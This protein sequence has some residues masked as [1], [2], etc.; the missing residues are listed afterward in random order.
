MNGFSRTPTVRETGEYAV[1]GGI[2]DLY[3]PGS[4][5][6]GQARLFRRH[7]GVH[8]LIQRRDPAHLETIEAPST[9][10]R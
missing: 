1:R 4:E 2:I 7:A 10:C 8:T 9:L 5:E 6:P 3:A